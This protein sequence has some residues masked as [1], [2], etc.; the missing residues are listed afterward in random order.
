M[1]FIFIKTKILTQ[2]H[3]QEK[4][5]Q[6]V[7]TEDFGLGFNLYTFVHQEIYYALNLYMKYEINFHVTN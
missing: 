1:T 5:I 4:K 7:L 3:F 2:E 6:I